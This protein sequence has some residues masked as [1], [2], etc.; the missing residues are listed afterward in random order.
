MP[1]IDAT[2][3]KPSLL[4]RNGHFNTLYPY[5]FRKKHDHNY[6]RIRVDTADGDFF[7]VDFL[8]SGSSK[9]VILLHGLEG[10]SD[11]QYIN[12]LTKVFSQNSY[13]VAAVNF[14]SCSGEMN[15]LPEMYHSG[16]TQDIPTLINYIEKDYDQIVIVGFSL[17]GNV[18]MKFAGEQKQNIHPKIK[19]IAGVSVP[20]D[21]REGSIKLKKWYNYPY[22]K[23]FLKTLMKK[24]VQKAVLHP[25]VI[26]LQHVSKVKS[27]WD[28]DEYYTA[29]MHGFTGAEDYYAQSNS[30]QF[31]ESIYVPALMINAKDDSFLPRESYPFNA[32]EANP[33][34][35]LMVPDYGGHVGFTTHGNR[36]YWTENKI[37]DFFNSN[38]M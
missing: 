14:R 29:S 32:A 27:L 26:N 19:A 35:H 21:L 37:L 7:D 8:T 1:I 20:C 15:R 2:S 12:G 3:Y 18:A 4:L 10:S 23:M 16:Y 24:V 11:S 22:E 6:H 9:I 17:G 36:M 38:T 33:N 34:F 28:F 5:Y 31:L 25:D 13:D 30:K